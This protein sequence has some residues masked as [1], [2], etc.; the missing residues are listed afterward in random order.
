MKEAVIVLVSAHFIA[1][2]LLQSDGLQQRKD[3]FLILLLHAAWVAVSGYLLLQ[4]WS[5]WIPFLLI[6]VFHAAIDGIKR[7]FQDTVRVFC[8][9]Q[10][11]HIISVFFVVWFCRTAGWMH[12]FSGKGLTLI[13]LVAGFAVCVPGAGF[14]VGKVAGKLQAE[15]ALAE[16]IIGLIN[17]GKL[18]GQLERALIFMLVMIGQPGGIGFLVAAKSILRFGEAKDDQ[19][20]AE[21]VLIGTLLSF[22]LAIAAST[23]TKYILE[24][25][26][27]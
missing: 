7:R 25:V 11:A 4:Q 9:D 1:D 19:K 26:S 10:A 14:L 12:G 24:D 3:R 18:I 20:L 23:L 16:K 21:Y 15:N 6:F 17:G 8:L 5:A 27:S 2:F 22:G 13:V